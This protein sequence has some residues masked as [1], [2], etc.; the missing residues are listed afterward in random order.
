MRYTAPAGWTEQKFS[1]G[2]VFKPADLPSGEHLSIQIMQPVN[3]TGTLE[4][5]LAKSFDEAAAMY[6]ATKMQQSG[7]NYGTNGPQRSFNGWEY[8]RGKGGVQI[9]NGAELGLELFV[10][11][12][13][14]RIERV[15]ISESRKYCGGVSR[16][17]VSDRIGYRDG[18]ENLLYSLQFADFTAPP[19]KT[20]STTGSGITGVWQGTIQSTGAAVG[21]RLDVFSP[22]FLTNGQVYF[23]PKFP[24]QGLDGLNTRIPP[25][26][27]PRDWG[28]YVFSN[29]KGV[30]NMPYGE[31]P[32]R[33]E[34]NKLLVTK[35]QRDWPFYKLNSV[36]GATFDG[37]YVLR[38]VNRQIP[39]ITFSSDGRFTDRG[40]LKVL[41]H[42][43][44]D[45][46]N[47][48]AKPGS[49]V[50]EVRDYSV[51]F[52]YSDGRKIKLAFLGAEYTKGNPA[53]ASLRMS[54]NE[55]QLVRQ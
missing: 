55:D 12:I 38:E 1:D 2:V 22:I 44:N 19:L 6:K 54:F 37:T 45:C 3:A 15:A 5:A 30:L 21:V 50:Y 39:S 8:I 46:L 52:T 31:I 51:L 36:D 25:E 43:G 11:R 47:P 53:P 49:G 32:I 48:G 13:N 9:E 4:Q 41:F 24:T 35:N 27:Y 18:I 14:N 34:G 33:T 29:G 17:Y 23:G 26:L 28:T 16:Y 42:D 20:G 40:A 10:V 7:G